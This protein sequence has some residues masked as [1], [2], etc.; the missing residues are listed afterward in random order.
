MAAKQLKTE[1]VCERLQISRG[2]WYVLVRRHRVRG[3]KLGR[4]RRWPESE[5]QRVVDACSRQMR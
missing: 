4:A 3:V 5:V 2:T 1:E